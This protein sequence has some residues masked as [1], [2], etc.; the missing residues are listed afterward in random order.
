MEV[1]FSEEEENEEERVV[2]TLSIADALD[3]I[4]SGK[5]SSGAKMGLSSSSSKYPR[6]WEPSGDYE[7]IKRGVTL[8][9]TP[10]EIGEKLGPGSLYLFRHKKNDGSDVVAFGEDKDRPLWY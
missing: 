4:K 3:V 7:L 9:K 6:K 1:S 2:E 5:S 8:M 10:E